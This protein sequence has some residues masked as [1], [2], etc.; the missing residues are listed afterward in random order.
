MNIHKTLIIGGVGAVTIGAVITTAN[1][2]G[3]LNNIRNQSTK[4]ESSVQSKPHDTK[5]VE[6]PIETETI[7][8]TET[9]TQVPQS[10]PQTATEQ[11]TTPTVASIDELKAQYGWNSL[12][13][14]PIEMMMDRQP[15]YFTEQY[16]VQAFKY[17]HDAG[18]NA[19]QKNG[20]TSNNSIN[21]A[22]LQ[23]YRQSGDF[24][25]TG[26]ALGVD[27]NSYLGG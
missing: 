19:A 4:K 24:V 12:A 11:N 21:Y 22:W 17:M 23:T 6:Q 14:S 13:G 8:T 1:L 27:W 3:H 2:S 15:E 16:R 5:A 10:A 20:S 7:N 9:T 18:L 25:A 26:A